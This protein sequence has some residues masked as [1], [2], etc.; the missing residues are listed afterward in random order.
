MLGPI[1]NPHENP[2]GMV[3][4]LSLGPQEEPR[5]EQPL[6]SGVELREGQGGETGPCLIPVWGLRIPVFPVPMVWGVWGR[7]AEAIL[8]KS[9]AEPCTLSHGLDGVDRVVGMG[10]GQGWGLLTM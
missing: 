3:L 8:A 7:R 2:E 1:L 4:L 6:V 5:W 9:H 10:Q